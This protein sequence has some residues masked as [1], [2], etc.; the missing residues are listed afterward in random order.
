QGSAN[1]R[2]GKTIS[3][4]ALVFLLHRIH[5]NPNGTTTKSAKLAFNKSPNPHSTPTKRHAGQ[6]RR[7]GEESTRYIPAITNAVIVYSTRNQRESPYSSGMVAA[8][9]MAAAAAWLFASL[10]QTP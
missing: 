9:E 5:A 1:A 4:A 2:H 3:N 10:R 6:L 8:I 7:S